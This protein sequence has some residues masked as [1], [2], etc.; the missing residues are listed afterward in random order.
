MHC[1]I[2]EDNNIVLNYAMWLILLHWQ[3]YYNYKCIKVTLY[4]LNLQIVTYQV[5]MVA[6]RN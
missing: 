2:N 4:A 3:S 5:S 1:I 6:D